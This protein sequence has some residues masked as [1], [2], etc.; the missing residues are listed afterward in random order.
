MTLFEY[1]DYLTFNDIG[2]DYTVGSTIPDLIKLDDVN[3]V[4]IDNNYGRIYFD[5]T[6]ANLEDATIEFV[7][8]LAGQD[9]TAKFE[10]GEF[11]YYD[12][13]NNI[14]ASP[15]DEEFEDGL[16]EAV[17]KDFKIE[18]ISNISLR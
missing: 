12:G 18:F 14:V 16:F 17:I 8:N 10:N 1:D 5:Y 6:I 9:Y 4:S 2:F 7:F 3:E 15:F 11:T 13:S